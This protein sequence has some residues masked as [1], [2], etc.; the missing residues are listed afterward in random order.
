MQITTDDVE[1]L[2]LRKC[3]RKCLRKCL[4]KCMRKCPIG[5]HLL[6]AGTDRGID[7]NYAR[8]HFAPYH[9]TDKMQGLLKA[10][11]VP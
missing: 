6:A 2:L 11:E 5:D 8:F 3:P 7:N 4:R 9:H 10:S 1:R